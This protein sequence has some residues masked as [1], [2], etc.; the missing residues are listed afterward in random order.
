MKKRKGSAIS[1]ALS[2][3][4]SLACIFSASAASVYA[5]AG[6]IPYGV[7]NISFDTSGKM[8]VAGDFKVNGDQP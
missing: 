1:K 2:I 3:M 6:E 8:Y 4:A 7:R 5:G